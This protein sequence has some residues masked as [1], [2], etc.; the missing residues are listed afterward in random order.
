MSRFFRVA[1]SPVFKSD[2]RLYCTVWCHRFSKASTHMIYFCNTFVWRQGVCRAFSTIIAANEAHSF[3]INSSTCL[4]NCTQLQ[5]QST[6]LFFNE[7]IRLCLC[8]V[9]CIV[10]SIQMIFEVLKSIRQIRTRN[11]FAKI[12]GICRVSTI[13]DPINFSTAKFQPMPSTLI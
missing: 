9:H 13:H 6:V 11:V 4:N 7:S 12:P 8:N 1:F 2:S 5:Q 3:N 10:L